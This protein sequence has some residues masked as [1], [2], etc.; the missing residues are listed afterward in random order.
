VRRFISFAAVT[1]LVSAS[2]AVLVYSNRKND[3]GWDDAKS[4]YKLYNGWFLSPEGDRVTLDGD[5]P[6]P[7]VFS[8]DGRFAIVGTSGYNDHSLSVIDWRTGVIT[9]FH[10]VL[11]SSFG[12]A[13]KG[14]DILFSGGRSEGKTQ[15]PDIHRWKLEGG[16][17]VKEES[18][19]LTDIPGMDR[20]VSSILPGREGYFVA[21]AQSDEIMRI[22]DAGTIE[23]RVKVGY[24]PRMLAMSPDGQSLAVSEWGDAGVLV[25]DPETLKTKERFSTLSQ[26]TAI[27]YHPDGRL[28]VAESGSNT[29]LQIKDHDVTR[30]TVSIDPTHPVGPTPTGLAF[31]KDGNQLFVTLGGEN[32]VA[33]L[34][35]HGPRPVLTG[36]IP[37]ERYPTSVA[38]SP[39]GTKLLV[40]TAKGFYG[41]SEVNG[42][43]IKGAGSSKGQMVGRIAILDVPTE[44]QLSLMT[45]KARQNIPEGISG[46]HLAASQVQEALKN[47]KSIKHVIYVLKENKSYDQ[48]LGDIPGANGDP[49]V[50]LFGQKITPNMHAMASQFMIFDNLYCDGEGSQVG[51]QWSDAAYAGQYTET[52]WSTNYGGKS[53]MT[54]DKRLTSSPGEYIWSN[55]RKQGIW[56]RVYGEYVDVQEDHGSLD[57][58][59]IKADPERFGY[60]EPWEKVFAKGGRDTEKLDTFLVELK[61]FEQS[62][63]M[64]GFM[65]MA[66]PD[67]HTHGYGAGSFSPKAMIENND[68]AVGRLVEAI[69]HSRFWKDTAIFIIQDDT[70]GALDHVDSHR[71]Y[72]FVISPWTRKHSVD[73]T[74]YSTASVLLTMEKILGLP[75]MSSYDAQATPMLKPF[76][77]TQNMASFTS[78]PAGPEINDKNPAKTSLSVM[79]AK[80][81]WSD[82]D[83]GDPDAISRLLWKG[84]R[85]GAPYPVI[86]R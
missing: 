8:E 26:P 67:D 9:D 46:S 25:L 81:D 75:P 45:K 55:A 30:V 49:S 54:S 58:P 17:L 42:K 13:I 31:T 48:V 86:G 38:V 28:F 78:L 61:Q 11:R 18:V 82:I 7:I 33:V 59:E 24:R 76:L 2:F 39:D 60:S 74:H 4:Q 41:P 66:L 84:E 72:G 85:P 23:T 77:G 50:T 19:T 27:A 70:Q 40:A 32:A 43:E 29:I 73:S 80:I 10:K 53:E 79:S 22:S 83:R 1:V 57:S 5:M 16:K 36:H 69:S 34:N 65:M 68:V 47:L 51:H 21:N 12:L 20:F 14:N 37:T 71:T 15:F 64:P 56:S 44:K 35:I 3:I 62:G 6:G 52:Q 63:K